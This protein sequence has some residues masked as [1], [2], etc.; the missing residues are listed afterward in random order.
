MVTKEKVQAWRDKLAGELQQLRS[1]LD[2]TNG[3]IQ[4]LDKLLAEMDS[5]EAT[6]GKQ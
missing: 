5:T 2:A 4:I 6:D 1:N 3:A